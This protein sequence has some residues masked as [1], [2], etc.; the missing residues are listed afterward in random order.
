MTSVSRRNYDSNDKIK[1]DLAPQANATISVAESLGAVYADLNRLS[2]DYLNSIGPDNGHKYNL[3][4]NDNTHISKSGSVL[5]G[6]M[7]S[8]L[9]VEGSGSASF[10]QWTAPNSTIVK[11]IKAGTFILPD[12]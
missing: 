11:D 2:T 9:L 5:F 3:N 8:E 10:K 12:A 4:P 6:N 7:V 1:E